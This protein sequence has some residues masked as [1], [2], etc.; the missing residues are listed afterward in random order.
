MRHSFYM[1]NVPEHPPPPSG[2]NLMDPR[3][4]RHP[5]LLI[6]YDTNHL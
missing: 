6:F 1:S 3:M 2:E 4:C 5:L